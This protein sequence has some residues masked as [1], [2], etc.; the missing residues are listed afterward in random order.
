MMEQERPK[1]TDGASWKNKAE[2]MGKELI[3]TRTEPVVTAQLWD[4]KNKNFIREGEDI[5]LAGDKIVCWDRTVRLSDEDNERYNFSK[6]YV[7]EFVLGSDDVIVGLPKTVH[8]LIQNLLKV[9]QVNKIELSSQRFV[10]SRTGT[11]LD[12]R[13]DV[14]LAQV[15]SNEEEGDTAG[16]DLLSN[17]S[18]KE[19]VLSPDEIEIMTRL[20]DV[21]TK[22]KVVSK[23]D[24]ITTMKERAG[25]TSERCVVLWES[26]N[27]A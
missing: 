6:Q 16:A 1:Y 5:G 17:A 13:Y 15:V 27:Q 7:Y 10:I 12:T 3:L 4:T 19:V 9:L 14:N 20:K 2:I 25:C 22:G 24:F 26:F 11:G 18:K 23:E 21:K 8:E